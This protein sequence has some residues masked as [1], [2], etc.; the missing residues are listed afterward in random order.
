MLAENRRRKITELLDESGSVRVGELSTLFEV[1]EET[2]RRDLEQLERDGYLT[3]THGGAVKNTL[4]QQEVAFYI[5]NMRN[6]QEKQKIGQKALD[7]IED[8]E[9]IALD[10][11]T[12][13]LQVARVLKEGAKKDIV[14]ITHA[15]KVVMTLADN[16]N[17][18][19]ISTGGILDHRTMSFI[20]PLAENALASYNIKKAF[21]SC[22]GLT[23]EE[24]ITES[25]DVQA[26][27]KEHLIKG[28]KEVFMLADHDKFGKA[29]L[30]TVAPVTV[31]KTLITDSGTALDRLDE[32]RAAG[33]DVV[34]TDS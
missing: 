5:R 15:L 14:V 31:I 1:T 17:L 27:I 21:V 20:G 3:R 30:A 4:D 28:A 13:A 23:I 16:A 6:H 12:T 25:T 22:K 34:V 11:S 26:R 9:V 7:Y 33:I 19:V 8:G 32:Y 10:A 2:I 29:A 18:T 24:G